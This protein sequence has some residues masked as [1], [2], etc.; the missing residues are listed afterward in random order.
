MISFITVHPVFYTEYATVGYM[1]KRI[2]MR[3]NRIQAL[4]NLKKEKK[5]EAMEAGQS[6]GSCE[7]DIATLPK[8]TVSIVQLIEIKN[9]W[10]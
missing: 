9:K 4:E 3:K 8:Q 6:K 7:G 2:L 10:K 1:A 5:K